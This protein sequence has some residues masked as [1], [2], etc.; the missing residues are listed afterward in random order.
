MATVQLNLFG[1]Q[2]GTFLRGSVITDQIVL[3]LPPLSLACVS[4]VV[5]ARAHKL[6]VMA[7]PHPPPPQADVAGNV[8]PRGWF[9]C[10][11]AGAYPFGV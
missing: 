9:P 4:L 5:G 2:T 6:P 10:M 7:A 1:Y 8:T 11:L 3:I